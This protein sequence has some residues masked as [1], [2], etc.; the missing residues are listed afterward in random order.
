MPGMS[1]GRDCQSQRFCPRDMSPKAQNPGTVQTIFDLKKNF[2]EGVSIR[3]R[4]SELLW[5]R[6]VF[7]VQRK[8]FFKIR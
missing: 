1:M 5:K 3:Y 7:K 2:G 8:I 4:V 6:G